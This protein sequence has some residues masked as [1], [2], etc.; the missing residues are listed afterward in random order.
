MKAT[1]PDCGREI[2]VTKQGGMYAHGRQ[3]GKRCPGAGKTPLD[4]QPQKLAEVFKELAEGYEPSE[5]SLGPQVT[6]EVALGSPLP[7]REA[8]VAPGVVPTFQLG[9]RVQKGPNGPHGVVQAL[10]EDG[11]VFVHWGTTMIRDPQ[12]NQIEN[13]FENWMPPEELAL[14]GEPVYYGTPAENNRVTLWEPRSLR[15]KP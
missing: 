15:G 3:D 11:Q 8:L 10:R 5:P 4:P 9:D 12:G 14:M 1:C 7:V 6:Q 2:G 13:R